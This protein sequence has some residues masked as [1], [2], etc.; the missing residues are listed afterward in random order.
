[1]GINYA[2][3]DMPQGPCGVIFFSRHMSNFPEPNP[4]RAVAFFDGQNLFYHAK[5]AFGYDYPNYDPDKLFKVLCEQ[6]GWINRGVRFY[7]GIPDLSKDPKK[8]AFWSN[9]NLAMRRSGILVTTRPLRYSYDIVTFENGES[10]TIDVPREKGID[11]RIAL[12]IIRLSLS[13]DLDVVVIFSQDQDLSEVANEIREIAKS[14][15]RW[16]KVYSAFPVSATASASRGIDK[17]DWIKI[18]K[19]LY[20]SCIDTKDYRPKKL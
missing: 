19:S 2:P 13:G 1:M 20:D 14:Q 16:I 4:K 11:I 7:T 5:A 15:Q 17:T 6:N 18:N 12:D 10:R 3:Q 9:K 8:H